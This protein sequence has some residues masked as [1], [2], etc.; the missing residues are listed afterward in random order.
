M[1]GGGG[2]S[3]ASEASGLGCRIAK[4]NVNVG[5]ML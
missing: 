3:E 5:K 4:K 2:G 1:R